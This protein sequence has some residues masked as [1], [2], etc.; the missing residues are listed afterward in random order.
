LQGGSMADQWFYAHGGEKQGPFSTGKL[1][2]LAATG[3]ILR[4]DTIFKQ[5]VLKGSLATKVKHLFPPGLA[6]ALPVDP[7]SPPSDGPSSLPPPAATP[8]PDEAS[9]AAAPE[10]QEHKTTVDLGRSALT[11]FTVPPSAPPAIKP[12]KKTATA[13]EGAIIISQDGSSV[14]YRK[15]CKKCQ[16]ENNSRNTMPIRSGTTRSTFFC[17]KCKKIQSVAIHGMT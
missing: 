8:S 13:G 2:E 12:R 3:A 5:G 10:P 9:S 17:P 7:T 6:T 11:A 15:K 1:Q 16:Y 4:T 14:S